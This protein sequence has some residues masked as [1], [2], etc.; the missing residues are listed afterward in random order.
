MLYILCQVNFTSFF[1]PTTVYLAGLAAA[2]AKD[3]LRARLLDLWSQMYLLDMGQKHTVV[4]QH[5]VAAV[6]HDED[7]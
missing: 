1:Q 4:V 3:V 6:T 2:C 5:L 7:M